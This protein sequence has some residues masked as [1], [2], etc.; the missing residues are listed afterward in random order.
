MAIIETITDDSKFWGW[1]Q[2]SDSYKNNFSY[3]GAKALQAYLDELSDDLGENIEFDPIA[4]CC[5]YSEYD[6]ALEAYNEHHGIDDAGEGTSIDDDNTAEN[7]EAQALEWLQDNT[8][9]IECGD[10]NVILQDF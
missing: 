2:S 7:A 3:K 8:T 10:G 4:W 1:V 9:V 5:E 6:S